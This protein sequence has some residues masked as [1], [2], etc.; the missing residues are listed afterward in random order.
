MSEQS[1]EIHGLKPQTRGFTLIELLV[2]IA[3]I[4]ILA[5]ILFPVFAKVREKARQTSCLSNLK[6][7]SL[8]ALQYGQDN[9]ESY[10]PVRDWSVT[11]S[12]TWINMIYPYVK[13]SGV[14]KCPDDSSTAL[15][16]IPY[17][18]GATFHDS[19]LDNNL[20]GNGWVAAFGNTPGHTGFYST[21]Q[22][23]ITKPA[24]TVFFCDGGAQ[25]TTTAPYVTSSS[26]LKSAAYILVDPTAAGGY[27]SEPD[28]TGSGQNGDAAA[29]AVRHT[30]FVNIAFADGHAKA[31]R[32]EDFYYP[33]SPW[34]DPTTGG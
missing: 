14:Y 28:G 4:A 17:T 1:L 7:I 8:A 27:A 30:G 12:Q 11:P 21:L 10:F 34:L 18:A 23:Q 26:P 19:Y 6:Q 29:P 22:S 32:P 25:S 31:M 2:V 5:A 15:V 20:F 13:S 9:N 24:S 3:I 33:N 16:G